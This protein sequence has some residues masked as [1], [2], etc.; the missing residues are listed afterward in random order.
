MP[1][2]YNNIWIDSSFNS[3]SPNNKDVDVEIVLA[4]ADVVGCYSLPIIYM[5][6]E[7]EIDTINNQVEY[8]QYYTTVSGVINVPIEHFAIENIPT[9]DNG[10]IPALI[11]YSTGNTVVSETQYVY[12]Y[13]Q[14]GFVA[15]DSSFNQIVTFIIG[16]QYPGSYSSYINVW[17]YPSNDTVA[18]FITNYTNFSGNLTTSGIPIP[19]YVLDRDCNTVYSTG[20]LQDIG[21]L[22][23]I[24]DITFAGWV[25]FGFNADIYSTL[26]GLDPYCVFDI[27]TISGNVLSQSIDVYSTDLKNSS[28]NIDLF[29]SLIDYAITKT[30]ILVG[31]GHIGYKLLDVFSS[32]QNSNSI[33]CDIELL[34]LKITNF[35]LGE[36]QYTEAYNSI[37]VDVLDDVCPISVSGTYF[38]IN[39]IQVSGTLT[40]IPDG[41]RLVYDPIDNFESLNGPTTFT[42]HAENE[43]GKIIEQLFNLTF[44]YIVGYE[45]DKNTGIDYGFDKKIVVRVEVENIAS[46]AR[47]SSIA[48]TLESEEFKNKELMASIVGMLAEE[49]KDI[50]ASVYPQS[51][52]YFYGKEFRIVVYAKDFAGNDMTP[53]EIAYK[54]E[55]KPA[56]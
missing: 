4:E 20:P 45:N 3:A 34:S 17:L 25:D 5:T 55:D 23:K 49:S 9:Y 22:D 14:T 19:V 51:T 48:Y 40:P 31:P 6:V 35:S 42:V 11:F 12:I 39:D 24:I 2:S 10:I 27:T 8:L 53:F 7:P 50:A 26:S 56:N 15:A 29:C 54:I 28:V 43:C 30:D 33:A 38:K 13:Y 52:V 16:N 41:Y 36:G 47:T 44:G 37:T 46:C 18:S 1:D 32:M 21:Q